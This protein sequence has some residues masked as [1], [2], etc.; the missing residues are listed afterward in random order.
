LIEEGKKKG[1]TAQNL[2]YK[3]FLKGLSSDSE[4]SP[5]LGSAAVLHQVAGFSGM[6]AIR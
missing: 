3:N 1:R 2:S 6:W 4:I 5:S